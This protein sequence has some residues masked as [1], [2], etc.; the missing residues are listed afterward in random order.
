MWMKLVQSGIEGDVAS[1]DV[2]SLTNHVLVKPEPACYFLGGNSEILFDDTFSQLYS[3]IKKH[4]ARALH[5]K[6]VSLADACASPSSTV[7]VSRVEA[8]VSFM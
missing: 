5:L 7:Q 3:L 4:G 8:L 1:R 2:E 6:I